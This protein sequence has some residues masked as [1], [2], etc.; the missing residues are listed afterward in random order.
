V[1]EAA[2]RWAAATGATVIAA[3]TDG[4]ERAAVRAALDAGGLAVSVLAE[5]IR[6]AEPSRGRA[7][8]ATAAL[9]TGAAHVVLSPCAPEQPWSVDA[10]MACNATIAR[11]C[12]ALVAIRAG[13][14]GATL[15]AGMRVLAAG[16]PVLAVGATAG[17]RLL[18]DYGATAA[19]DE[20]ELMWWLGTRLPTPD[21]RR[22]EVTAGRPRLR[23][24][25][26]CAGQLRLRTRAAPAA[27]V[28]AR[29]Q[30]T[31]VS[32][33]AIHCDTPLVRQ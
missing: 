33:A 24:T 23:P 16:R 32:T 1:A 11:L 18:V 25:G 2:A 26:S 17:S 7:V 15:D 10:A 29:T 27:A 13:G 3:D 28:D 5:G 12:T 6:R 14:T 8:E 19:V 4:P 30:P 9:S 22:A 21:D 31:R 20:V